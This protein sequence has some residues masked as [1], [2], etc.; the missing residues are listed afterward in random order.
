MTWNLGSCSAERANQASRIRHNVFRPALFW[1]GYYGHR[2]ATRSEGEVREIWSDRRG[3]GS[4]CDIGE[5]AAR[6]VSQTI[7]FL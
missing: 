2:C 3:K 1:M 5:S 6:F 4:G 7:R